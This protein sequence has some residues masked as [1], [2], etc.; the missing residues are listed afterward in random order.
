MIVA[1]CVCSTT[2]IGTD[3]LAAHLA[4]IRR[5]SSSTSATISRSPT[6]SATPRMREAH[7]PG[8][9]FAHSIA[10][11]RRRRPD[12]T[13]A[14]RCPTPEAAAALFGRLG[15][16]ATKQVVAY[17]QGS[18]MFAARLWWMLRWLGHDSGRRARRRIR[19][20]AARRPTGDGR[21]AG[22]AARRRSCRRAC[23]RR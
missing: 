15:I 16:D 4:A 1:S 18:G 13:A 19:E 2:L 21:R 3:A 10:T 12:A 9:R 20:V 23:V 11:C 8:A 6:S 17:D 14:I 7:I 22:R 5:S